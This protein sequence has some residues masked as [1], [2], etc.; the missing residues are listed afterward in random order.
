MNWFHKKKDEEDEQDEVQ[1]EVKGFHSRQLINQVL[2]TTIWEIVRRED[3][4][5][6]ELEEKEAELE[7][8][9]RTESKYFLSSF[10]LP[11]FFKEVKLGNLN[12]NRLL[13]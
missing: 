3:E 9:R 8:P 7:F 11:L 6:K 13:F 2:E 12:L 1:S 4:R 5:E 10:C